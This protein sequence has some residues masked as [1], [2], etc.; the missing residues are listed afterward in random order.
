[1]NILIPLAGEKTFKTNDSNAFPKILTEVDGRLL[2]ERAAEPYVALDMP[3]KIIVA[4]PKNESKKFRLDKVLKLL[5]PDIE[6]CHINSKTRGTACSALLAIEHLNLDE[7]LI[8]SSFEQVLDF[9][10]I[11]Y[12]KAFLEE[13]V[14]AGVL[15]FDAIHPKWSYVN[16]DSNY[17]VF[18]VAEKNPISRNAVAGFYFFKKASLF[19]ESAKSMIRKDEKT[20]ELFYIAPVIN[21]IILNDGTVRAIPINKE[22]YFHINDEHALENYEEIATNKTGRLNDMVKLRTE[23]YVKAFN[24]K[25]IQEVA[26]FFSEGFVLIDPVKKVSGK[27][28]VIDY[29]EGIFNSVDNLSFKAKDIIFSSKQ[30]VI[31]FELK[32]DG[33]TL[34]GTDVIRWDDDGLMITMDAY[35]YE[36]NDEL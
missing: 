6:T 5:S 31:E 10:L 21:E 23:E 15:T 27:K 26:T 33:V 1:M 19:I 7:P 17:N 30:S 2:I 18:Q 29:I 12:L 34:I 36:K 4:L 24:D 32:L 16:F 11:P 8:V 13:K 28:S 25:N 20:N 9:S 22:C 35:L 14:D 3:K